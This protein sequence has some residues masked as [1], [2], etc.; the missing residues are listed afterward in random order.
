MITIG[1]RRSGTEP[2]RAKPAR[3]PRLLLYG[4]SAPVL[5]ITGGLLSW[6]AAESGPDAS[7]ALLIIAAL[8]AVGF[9][10]SVVDAAVLWHR[11]RH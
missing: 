3:D 10:I 1:K 8:C 9:L 11:T 5:L 2:V 7:A 6:W 4:V